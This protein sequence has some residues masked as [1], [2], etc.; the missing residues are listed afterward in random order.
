[1]VFTDVGLRYGSSPRDALAIAELVL[2]AG[3]STAIVGPSG[4]GKTSILSLIERYYDPSRG[5]IS[6]GGADIARFPLREW[7]RSI[8]YV[9]QSAPLLS[10]TIRE[11]MEYGLGARCDDATLRRAAEAA[12]C[13]AFVDSLTDGFDSQ[14]GEAGVRLSG[15]QRQRIAIARVFLRDPLLLLLDEPTSSLDAESEDAVLGA[16]RKLMAGRTTV[17]VTHRLSALKDVENIA[18][19][20]GGSVTGFGK[21]DDIL[22]NTEYFRRISGFQDN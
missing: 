20:E 14:V 10:G 3:E 21:R 12:H 9:A 8:G 13:L 18:I 17:V 4:A 11:N 5:Q 7:R 2:P 1:L 6:W 19:L 15:G 22:S 16:I